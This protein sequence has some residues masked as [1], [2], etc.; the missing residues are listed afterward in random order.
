MNNISVAQRI[1]LTLTVA[2]LMLIGVGSYALWGLG[3]A[4]TRFEYVQEN[5]VPSVKVLNEASLA[6]QRLRVAV[7]DHVLAENDE[8]KTDAEKRVQ[9]LRL[10]PVHT[11]R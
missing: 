10:G 4:Q 2:L 11:N 3:A 7:R 8:E 6:V 9:E 5:T 1:T